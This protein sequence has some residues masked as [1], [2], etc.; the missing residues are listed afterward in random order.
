MDFPPQENG[1][2]ADQQQ[3]MHL[4]TVLNRKKRKN[5]KILELYT[6]IVPHCSKQFV[7]KYSWK[8]H[9]FRHHEVGIVN[10]YMCEFCAKSFVDEQVYLMRKSEIEA[11]II[12]NAENNKNRVAKRKP[13]KQKLQDLTVPPPPL[14][15]PKTEP[16]PEYS[17][18]LATDIDYNTIQDYLNGFNPSTYLNNNN[19]NMTNID[20]S[21][22]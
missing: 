15:A 13:K 10:T 18:P 9:M 5:G 14:L 11:Q 21:I 17:L 16:M 19:N 7:S 12:E 1:S 20:P 8:Y 4:T 2:S 6:C 22:H 3:Q